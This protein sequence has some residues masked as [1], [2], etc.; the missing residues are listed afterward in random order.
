MSDATVLQMSK[1]D[2]IAESMRRSLPQ[3]PLEARHVVEGIIRPE[4]IAVVSGTLIVQGLI[5]SALGRLL[6]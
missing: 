3:L 6:I 5:S 2:K 1:A 4:T